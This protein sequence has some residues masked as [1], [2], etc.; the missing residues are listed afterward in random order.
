MRTGVLVYT[1][2]G[3]NPP[4]LR[5][6]QDALERLDQVHGLMIGAMGGMAYQEETTVLSGGEMLLLYT[7]GVTE[8]RNAE[9]DFYSEERLAALLS[10]H[11]CASTAEDAVHTIVSHVEGFRGEA[12]QTDDVTL[13]AIRLPE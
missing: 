1:N 10:T 5:R 3:H 2:A 8:A 4:Y 6:R 9:R 12:D 13:L 7:D 11:S